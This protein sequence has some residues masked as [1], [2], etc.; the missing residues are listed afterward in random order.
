[1]FR[2]DQSL[3]RIKDWLVVEQ[4][5]NRKAFSTMSKTGSKQHFQS[6]LL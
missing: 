1:M 2:A 5:T 3:F 4:E 6:L